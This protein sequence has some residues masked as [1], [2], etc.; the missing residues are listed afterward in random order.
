MAPE[1]APPL[2]AWQG[3]AKGQPTDMERRELGESDGQR[4]ETDLLPSGR[5]WPRVQEA[6]Q[7]LR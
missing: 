1:E 5:Q 4:P 3:K 2:F 6:G 7:W